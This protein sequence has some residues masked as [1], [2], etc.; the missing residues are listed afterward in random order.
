ME[1]I[2]FIIKIYRNFIL[3]YLAISFIFMYIIGYGFVIA[4]DIFKHGVFYNSFTSYVEIKSKNK[5]L[6]DETSEQKL[7]FIIYKKNNKL[8]KFY[9][10]KS[11]YL[12]ISVLNLNEEFKFNFRDMVLYSKDITE[13]NFEI[14]NEFKE[15]IFETNTQ[16]TIHKLDYQ[17]TKDNHIKHIKNIYTD[18]IMLLLLTIGFICFMYKK[19]KLHNYFLLPFDNKLFEIFG[20]EQNQKKIYRR[21]KGF[22]KDGGLIY[23]N[24]LK[25]VYEKVL[26][27]ENDIQQYLKINDIEI[28][29][30]KQKEIIIQET[31]LTNAVAFDTSKLQEEK[32][33]LGK[34]KGN[35]DK[36]LSIIGLQNIIII[37]ERGSG[38]SVFLQN[39]LT[40]FFFN[41]KM[42]EK[43]ILVD[44][45][46]V[47]LGRY[48]NY[49]K[50]EYIN[51]IEQ[52]KITIT[53]LQK[54]MYKRLD[55]MEETGSNKSDDD[56]ILCCIDEFR[57]IKNNGLESKELKAIDKI[58]IDLLQKCRATNIRLI[59]AGQ[60]RDVQN[61]S[62]N[63]L[64][65]IQTRVCLGTKD[66]DNIN[67]IAGNKEELEPYN[68]TQNKIKRFKH[69][70]GF[71]KDSE[72]GDC[73]LFQ[74]PFLDLKNVEHSN[75]VYSLLENNIFVPDPEIS[76]VENR[77]IEENSQF[78]ELNEERNEEVLEEREQDLNSVV[79]EQIRKEIWS[80]SYAL[81]KAKRSQVR[82][83][84]IRVKKLINN[85]ELVKR[86]KKLKEVIKPL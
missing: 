44:F 65:N 10:K 16:T 27:N 18:A 37:G 67:K 47:E 29:R 79:L 68:L 4:Q 81:E 11:D 41:S 84:L 40:S 6:T 48:K 43:F 23:S 75:F 36:Y 77:R 14:E 19:S 74:S 30:Y 49:K 66:N 13:I 86:D 57:T 61:I 9:I 46:R 7:Y 15:A 35:F 5:I 25:S 80:M 72:S 63:V 52:F 8:K 56:F 53:A 39:L 54:T 58:L 24:K 20:T 28:Q 17:K 2:Q 22:T 85:N 69:G 78:S 50:I 59:F 31:N 51:N 55:K 71:Y 38:K 64:A 45:K 32:I 62:S 1:R 60:K 42:F 33:Y 76:L 82:K 34:E 21:F 3:Q 73:F 83:E 26:Q 70:K 12:K